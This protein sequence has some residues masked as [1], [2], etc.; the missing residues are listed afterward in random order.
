MCVCVRVCVCMK[1]CDYQYGEWKI[2]ILSGKFDEEEN[3][4]ENNKQNRREGR[5]SIKLNHSTSA[6]FH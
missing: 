4:K 2:K 6:I 5:R 1:V 3:K